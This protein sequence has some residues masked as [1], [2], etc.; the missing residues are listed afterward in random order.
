VRTSVWGQVRPRTGRQPYRLQ[1]FRSG[2]W[3]WVGATRLTSSAGFLQR[4]ISGG[5]GTLL[6]VWSPRDHRYSTNLRIT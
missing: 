1:Q 3:Q 5:P 2:R 6:R 4:V